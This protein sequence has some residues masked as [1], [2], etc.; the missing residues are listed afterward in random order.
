MT[1]FRWLLGMPAAALITAA[2]FFMMAEMIRNK[3]IDYPEPT[4]KPD[5]KITVDLPPPNTGPVKPVRPILP[6]DP[7][8]PIINK[9]T[10]GERPINPN[11]RP[12]PGPVEVEQGTGGI[13][14]SGPS[15]RVTPTYPENC[16]SKGAEGVVIVEFDVTPEGNVTNV[17]VTH[18]PDRCFD[19]PIR[20][21]VSK[22]K[23][24]PASTNGRAATRYGV[25]ETFSFQLVE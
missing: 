25:V 22:W 6:N 5:L 17:R 19:R 18:S 21:A 8:E 3:H 10:R 12:E 11:V 1:L 20:N 16:R 4:P 23:Y 7:P 9:T 15:I 13:P 14:V 2:L 24:S